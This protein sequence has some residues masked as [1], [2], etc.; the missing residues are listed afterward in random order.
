MFFCQWQA[1]YAF[2]ARRCIFL[3]YFGIK[4]KQLTNQARGT[5]RMIWWYFK[6]PLLLH[7]EIPLFLA[8]QHHKGYFPGVISRYLCFSGHAV[9]ILVGL[10]F[11]NRKNSA[12][13]NRIQFSYKLSRRPCMCAG[14]HCWCS[15]E[16]RNAA[17]YC[18]YT[19]YMEKKHDQEE[20]SEAVIQ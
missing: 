1:L 3:V 5:N 20:T 9:G 4:V 18:M 19:I 11:G 16:E 2:W 14:R 17:P 12:G 13:L 15:Q 6:T 10:Y 7:F 8:F